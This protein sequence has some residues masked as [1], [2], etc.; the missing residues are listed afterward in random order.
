M[1]GSDRLLFVW[2][3][4]RF[5]ERGAG[6]G[7]EGGGEGREE[8][9]GKRGRELWERERGGRRDWLCLDFIFFFFL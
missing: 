8:E 6:E 5:L 7:D 1:I 9:L 4:F 2:M 3:L